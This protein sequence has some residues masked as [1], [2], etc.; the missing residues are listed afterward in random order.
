MPAR[1]DLV[2]GAEACHDREVATNH[3]IVALFDLDGTLIRVGDPVHHAAFEHAT[4][5]VFGAEIDI[6]TLDLAG[7]VDRHL[8]DQVA[9][10]LGMAADEA[11]ARFPEWSAILGRY[12]QLRVDPQDRADW[13][14][15]GATEVL[16]RLQAA[17]I[18]L[19]IATGSIRSVAE[20][21]LVG[22][23]LHE[24]FPAGAFGDEV[25]DRAGLVRRA[26][27]DATTRY[28]RRFLAADAVVIGDTPAD[29][30]AARHTG[31]RVVTVATGRFHTD[32]LDGHG[33]DAAFDDLSNTDA[34]V[35]AIRGVTT[36]P[37]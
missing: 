25:S 27:A 6:T 28:G 8:Y 15:P 9:S 7:A 1:R 16:R 32:E 33:P 22:A 5:V 23:G 24:Y 17:G 30:R 34:V 10:R 11:D 19:A 37:G 18:A 21:K 36:R 26:L 14:L 13:L 2:V 20:R 35:R 3:A 29:I 4:Q 12:Y 31:T